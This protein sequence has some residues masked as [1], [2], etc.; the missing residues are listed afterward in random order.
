MEREKGNKYR[1][2][3]EE[4]NKILRKS[5]FYIYLKSMYTYKYILS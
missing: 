5:L 1:R 3:I 4:E 2:G